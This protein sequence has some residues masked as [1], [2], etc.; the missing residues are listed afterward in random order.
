M[1][2]NYGRD[3]ATTQL[4]FNLDVSAHYIAANSVVKGNAACNLVSSVS[5]R[6]RE[7]ESP[8]SP[9]DVV[10]TRPPYRSPETCGA[11]T[12]MTFNQAGTSQ[13]ETLGASVGI[14][15]VETGY[16]NGRVQLVTRT[17]ER[18]GLPLIGAAFVRAYNPAVNDGVSGHFSVI[19]PHRHV[20]A[21]K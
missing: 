16:T 2:V 12:V 10:I 4:V 17:A 15:D 21:L 18:A 9:D 5:I 11:A 1:G 13:S 3:S 8:S 6:N 20:H 14:V 19:W 7:A